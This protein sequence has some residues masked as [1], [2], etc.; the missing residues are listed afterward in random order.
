[1][2]VLFPAVGAIGRGVILTLVVAT[3]LV[4]PFTVTVTVTV[5]PYVPAPAV[6]TLLITG[7]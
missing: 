4:Q 6:V 7:F 1:M 3:V 2:G 5:T